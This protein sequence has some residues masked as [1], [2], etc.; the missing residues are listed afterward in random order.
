MQEPESQSSQDPHEEVELLRE[1][2]RRLEAEHTEVQQKLFDQYEWTREKTKAFDKELRSLRSISLEYRLLDF[3]RRIY[4]RTTGLPEKTL[5]EDLEK[6]KIFLAAI[7]T[8][9]DPN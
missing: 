7:P 9:N 8:K 2:L 1:K 4:Q 6:L 5:E 3:V